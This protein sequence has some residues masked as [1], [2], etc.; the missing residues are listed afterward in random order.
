MVKH[1]HGMVIL[2]WLDWI[3]VLLFGPLFCRVS[4]TWHAD[5]G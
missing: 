3:L 2:V 5:A 1:K 4:V